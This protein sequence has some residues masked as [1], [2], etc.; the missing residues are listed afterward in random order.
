MALPLRH[1]SVSTYVYP[2]LCVHAYKHAIIEIVACTW[3]VTR[4]C[5]MHMTS[6]S[7]ML[8]AHDQLLEHV[9]CTW[10]VTVACCMHVTSFD[11]MGWRTLFC[12]VIQPG[13]PLSDQNTGSW[14]ARGQRAQ[15][16]HRR[17]SK[18]KIQGRLQQ[19]CISMGT[20][21]HMHIIPGN[22]W[23][24]YMNLFHILHIYVHMCMI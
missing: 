12:S 3:P 5:C 1:S 7:S 10:P 8:H 9:A 23:E 22:I 2:F 24:L 19:V 18:P 6:Y 15:D 17:K 16:A 20:N 4:A 14:T 11:V 21:V 13:K